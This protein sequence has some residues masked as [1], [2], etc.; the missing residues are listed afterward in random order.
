VFKLASLL[1]RSFASPVF[2]SLSFFFSVFEQRQIFSPHTNTRTRM[3]FFVV[4]CVG[5]SLP[6]RSVTV[7]SFALFYVNGCVHLCKRCLCDYQ[8]FFFFVRESPDLFCTRS[9]DSMRFFF[10][11][12]F[13][14][15]FSPSDAPPAEALIFAASKHKQTNSH[16]HASIGREKG[17]KR[18]KQ[19]NGVLEL[20]RLRLSVPHNL[21]SG[22]TSSYA[23]TSV[24]Q[25]IQRAF[26]AKRGKCFFS[27]CE[28]RCLA[29]SF[30]LRST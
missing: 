14:S 9:V 12:C 16:L 10:F 23:E 17:E 5:F 8:S 19:E 29:G 18:E 15:F 25:F 6:T 4:H 11:T 26:F 7:G 3:G 28:L 27:F 22:N 20:L 30:L 2:F 24:E 1:L 13:S 21:R